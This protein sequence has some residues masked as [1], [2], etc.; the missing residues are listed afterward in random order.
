MATPIIPTL[1]SSA[2]ILTDKSDIV[3]YVIRHVLAQAKKTSVHLDKFK[4]SFR[5]L[6]AEYGAN[7]EELRVALS[8]HLDNILLRYFPNGSVRV[9][10]DSSATDVNGV[11]SLE[12]KAT[13]YAGDIPGG[14]LILTNAKVSIKDGNVFNIAFKGAKL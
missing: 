3:A 10:I 6:E 2:G 13:S 4:V 7:T 5:K 12:I 8:R 11:Y 1:H 14:S 9:T